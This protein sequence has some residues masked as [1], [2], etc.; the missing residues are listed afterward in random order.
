LS[1]RRFIQRDAGQFLLG[2]LFIFTLAGSFPR[3]Y[4]TDEVQYYAWVRS[5]WFDHDVDFAN[6]YRFFAEKNPNAGI[7]TSLLLPNRIRPLTGLYGNIAPVGSALLWAPWFI[8]T[9]VA[10]RAAHAV[11]LATNIPADGY[12]WPYQRAICYA[13]AVYAFIGLLVTRRVARR[14]AS[15][16]SATVATI[17]MWLAT[18]LVFYMTVQ[19]PFAHAN[20]F[21]MTSL[22]VAAWAWHRDDIAAPR[23][24]LAMGAAL[25]GMF[26]VREQ[27]ILFGVLPAVS[28]LL[29]LRQ[30]SHTWDWRTL[31]RGILLA[32]I[33]C[34]VIAST[35]FAAYQAVNGVPKPASEVSGKLNLCSP[36]A[37]DTLIDY[38]PS[39]AAVCAVPPEPVS[40]PAWS[41]GALVWTPIWAIGLFG[42]LWM[43]WTL[44]T[45]ALPLLVTFALQMWLNGA[46]GTTW[47]LTGAFGFRRFIECTPM[48]VIGAAWLFD[49][50]VQRHWRLGIT[51]VVAI[52]V[53][54]NGGLIINATVFNEVTQMRRGLQWPAVWEWQFSLPWRLWEFGAGLFDRCRLLKNGC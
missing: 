32:A 33:G 50:S 21:F 49:R 36:H 43:S 53:V 3:V 46:F 27:L 7:A 17:G 34:L 54:W 30:Q 14:W 1:I 5:L 12:S 9:D 47:H 52:L 45:V 16:W 19:M 48:F 29:L 11:G 25:G 4:A 13:S 31:P 26:L 10:L 44:P 8:S 23:P 40:V 24:W 20:G 41:R 2:V 18:P 35:Q 6:E 42:L 22:F 51:V 38:D 39:P 15:D 28:L 37:V